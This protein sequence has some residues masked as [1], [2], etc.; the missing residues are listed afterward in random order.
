MEKKT[1]KFEVKAV[2]EGE[3]TFEGILSAFRKTPDKAKDI[4]RPGC[5]KK[6]VS[7]NPVIPTLYMHDL[8]APVG[9]M[10]LTE[11]NQGLAVKGKLIKGIQKAEE[12]LL[13]M[14][15]GVIKTLSMGYDVIQREFKDGVR[16]LTE[17]KVYEGSLVIGDFACDDE[18]VITSV[19]AEKRSYEE[20]L[21][22]ADLRSAGGRMLDVLYMTIDDIMYGTGDKTSELDAAI[23]SFHEKFIE[24]VGQMT[25]AGLLK[26]EKTEFQTKAK[27]LQESFNALLRA[28]PGKTTPAQEEAAQ[29]AGILNDMEAKAGLSERQAEARLDELL[30]K[31]KTEVK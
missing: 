4:A 20:N 8:N 18:A 28:E 24:W 9:T 5:F 25:D 11:T 17:V 10:E 13:L 22:L 23:T 29:L 30:S 14:K 15:A 6:T 31:I 12:S 1:F 21:Q 2:N 3:G 16:Y 19:K 27:N 26:I 7:E